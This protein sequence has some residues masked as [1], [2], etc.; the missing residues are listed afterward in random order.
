[1]LSNLI[2]GPLL[3]INSSDLL[4]FHSYRGYLAPELHKGGVI[5][6]SA[7]LYSLG[8]IIIEILTGHRG[9]E[10]IQDVRTSLLRRI[11]YT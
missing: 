3:Y 5:A 10:P 8:V 6:R 7:D 9:Y 11:L 4:Y 2:S 1:V